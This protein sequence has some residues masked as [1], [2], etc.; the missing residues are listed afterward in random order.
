MSHA[1]LF[2]PITLTL[3]LGSEDETRALAQ[4]IAPLLTPGDTLLL[5][6]P[7]GAGK[8]FFARTLIQTLQERDGR[9][10]EVPSPTFTLVQT[11]EV[12]GVEIWHAD[13]YRLTSPD[14]ITELGLEEAFA[15]AICLVEW[16]NRLDDLTPENALTLKFRAEPGTE[17]RLV[18]MAA[19]SPR[20]A[21]LL[22]DLAGWTGGDD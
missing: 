9:V 10:E 6:G 17:A 20:W 14:E 15:S 4:K 18:E 22:A 16:P 19:T 21:P 7:I 5:D 12:G 11:Y 1:Q 13:L 8:T 2:D 3:R